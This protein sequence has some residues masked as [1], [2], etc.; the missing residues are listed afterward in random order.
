[1]SANIYTFMCILTVTFFLLWAVCFFLNDFIFRILIVNKENTKCWVT[2]GLLLLHYFTCWEIIVPSNV[3][4]IH[5]FFFQQIRV[6]IICLLRF[7]NSRWKTPPSSATT[8][9]TEQTAATSQGN[10]L[11][12]YWTLFTSCEAK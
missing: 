2:Q 12:E 3:L 4:L 7:P 9:N 11:N 1:M 6:L 8:N 5:L 10:T